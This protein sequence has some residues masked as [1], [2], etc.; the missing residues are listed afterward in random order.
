MEPTYRYRA[1]PLNDE[2]ETVLPEGTTKQCAKC[3]VESE[4][5]LWVREH[6]CP[7]CGFVTDRDQNAAFEVQKRGLEELEVEYSLDDV[8]GLGE[9]KA[10]PVETA[11][12]PKSRSDFVGCTRASLL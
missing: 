8:L 2:V 3:S 4:K 11:T 6:S 1:Y 9:A 7:A 10:T 12:V 5:P